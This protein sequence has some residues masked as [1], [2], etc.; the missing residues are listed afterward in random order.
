MASII[1]LIFWSFDNSLFEKYIEIRHVVLLLDVLNI[2]TTY[3]C[4]YLIEKVKNIKDLSNKP[5]E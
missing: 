4:I 2:L 5:I 1:M 3:Q